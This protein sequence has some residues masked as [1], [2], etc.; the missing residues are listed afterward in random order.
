MKVD[1][2]NLRLNFV[3]ELVRE[4]EG[5]VT[6]AHEHAS[7]EINDGVA[8]AVFLAF[9]HSPAREA[10]RKICRTQQPLSRTV[11]VTLSHLEVFDDFALVPDV[12]PGRHDVNAEI[13]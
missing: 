1:E 3:Q 2:D 9:V 10:C 11:R 13:E 8:S 5:I 7:L 6:G 12:I 4:P